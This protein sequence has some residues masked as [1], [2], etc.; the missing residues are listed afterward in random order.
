MPTKSKNTKKRTMRHKK[1]AQR[2]G[3]FASSCMTNSSEGLGKYMSAQCRGANLHNTNPEA[4]D[5][6]LAQGAGFLPGLKGGACT[7]PKAPA[8]F[9]SY[10]N[11]VKQ[12]LGVD[13]TSKQAGG[14]YFSINP[15]EMIGGLPRVDK[16]DSC[17][18]GAVLGGKFV[19]GAGTGAL[20]GNQ[21]GGRRRSSKTKRTTKSHGK[22]K[23]K[24]TKKR[25]GT[26]RGGQR[27]MPA[28]F[29]D[30]FNAENGNFSPD[31]QGKDFACRQPFWGAGC[32]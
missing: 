17:C 14:S 30:A 15:E 21:M 31:A 4:G 3:Q 6:S 32:R 10:R 28:S 7:A 8:T 29:P 20:C 13:G 9:D 24:Q 2:G 23:T 27:S 12:Y 22:K 16:G 19:Q 5:L 26:Q 1:R 11:E 18:Q 25:K